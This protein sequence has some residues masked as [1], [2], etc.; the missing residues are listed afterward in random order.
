LVSAGF[1]AHRDDPMADLRLTSG[2]FAA[3]TSYVMSC[4]PH[5][6]R[7]VFFLEGGYDLSALRASIHATLSTALGQRSETE[8]PSHG[9]PGTEQVERMRESRE[10]AIEMLHASDETE[11]TP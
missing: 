9:G 2:D 6:G 4:V 5:S 3:M 11:S 10:M 1:D 8:A 7:V